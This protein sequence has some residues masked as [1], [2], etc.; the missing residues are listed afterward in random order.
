[1]TQLGVRNQSLRWRQ[2]LET[3]SKSK[4]NWREQGRSKWE[5]AER[6]WL[7][8]ASVHVCWWCSFHVQLEAFSWAQDRV[9]K[10]RLNQNRQGGRKLF[11]ISHWSHYVSWLTHIPAIRSCVG[12]P[13]APCP[14]VFSC[15]LPLHLRDLFTPSS[16]WWTSH[17]LS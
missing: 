17:F 9:L 2:G 14:P 15:T 4:A 8:P 12:S 3:C 11:P 6:L 10:K 5:M 16:G 7:G 1:M 13:K